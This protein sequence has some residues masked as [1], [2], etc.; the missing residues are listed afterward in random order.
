VTY[1]DLA[2]AHL[3]SGNA[4]EAKK[5]TAKL[6]QEFPHH[7]GA[8]GVAAAVHVELEEIELAKNAMAHYLEFEPSMTISIMREKFTFRD[9]VFRDR[10]M[11]ALRIAGM[12]DE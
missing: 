1:Y 11:S 12:P 2:Y 4:I 7:F 6:M 10:Y 3:A 9:P 5:W 8:N